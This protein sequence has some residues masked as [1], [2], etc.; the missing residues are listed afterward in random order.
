MLDALY[1]F[2]LLVSEEL[3]ELTQTNSISTKKG[4]PL[5]PPRFP[6]SKDEREC[7]C[8]LDV[9]W[10]QVSSHARREG[11]PEH[12]TPHPAFQGCPQ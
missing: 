5:S 2:P 8:S 10:D 6:I 1:R 7:L 12:S 3:W 11:L 9:I 4:G